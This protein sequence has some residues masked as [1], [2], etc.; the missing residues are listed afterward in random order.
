MGVYFILPHQVNVMTDFR[1]KQHLNCTYYETVVVLWFEFLG[2]FKISQV[3]LLHPN[4]RAESRDL[5]PLCVSVEQTE[6]SQ[7]QWYLP[8]TEWEGRNLSSEFNTSEIS[9]TPGLWKIRTS[10]WTATWLLA[11]LQE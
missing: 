2:L 5:R 1:Y 4:P 6:S 10:W 7:E 11:D 3:F 9:L 8:R